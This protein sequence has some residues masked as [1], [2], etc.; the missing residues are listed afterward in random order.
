MVV[1]QGNTVPQR[2]L[3]KRV[4]ADPAPEDGFRVLVDRL[5]P[6]GLSK[7]RAAVDHWQRELA[8]SDTLRHWFGHDPSRW[9]EFRHRYFAELD[10]IPEIVAGLRAELDA[11]PR[12]TLLYA[13]RD[14]THNN[15]VALLA[16]LE[17][18]DHVA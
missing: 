8:P 5:W 4:Y 6:R 17:R 11:H 7:E 16:Y 12:V 13:T 10:T 9:D 15:A 2:I 18:R 3:T 1:L 14:E